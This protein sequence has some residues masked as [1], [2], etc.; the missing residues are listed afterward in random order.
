MSR[1]ELSGNPEGLKTTNQAI[2]DKRANF[3]AALRPYAS[4]I[5]RENP[6]TS[7]LLERLTNEQREAILNIAVEYAAMLTHGRTSNEGIRRIRRRPKTGFVETEK[8]DPLEKK[9]NKMLEK[10]RIDRNLQAKHL[11]LAKSMEEDLTAA[12][13][14]DYSIRFGE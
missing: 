4:D 11:D 13:F 5:A 7:E 12:Y 14:M 8:V 2:L 6:Y 10:A 9:F 3:I 1:S